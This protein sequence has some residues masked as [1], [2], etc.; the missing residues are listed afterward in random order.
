MYFN[1]EAANSLGVPNY[2]TYSQAV[3]YLIK[4]GTSIHFNFPPVKANLHSSKV[5]ALKCA[6]T[7]HKT[8]SQSK[9][10]QTL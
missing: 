2:F 10:K 4:K 3:I 7:T 5:N 9:T 8:Y 1:Q 6:D